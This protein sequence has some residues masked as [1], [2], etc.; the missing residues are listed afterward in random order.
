MQAL[1]K[2]T[3]FVPH[4]LTEVLAEL[5]A[6]L[7]RPTAEGVL[8]FPGIGLAVSLLKRYKPELVPWI[9]REFVPL[10]ADQEPRGPQT[11]QDTWWQGLPMDNGI[12]DE[13]LP[14]WFTEIWIPISRTQ[15]V[16]TTLRDYFNRNGL[17]ATGTFSIE[18]YGAKSN[19]FWMSPSSDGEPVVRVDF[20]WFGYNAGDPAKEFYQ[21]FWDLLAQF[22]F[23]L[24]WGKYLPGDP[25][26]EKRWAKYFAAR[27][28]HW[29][30]FMALRA[31]LDPKNIFLT[32]YWR[33]HLGLEEA[34]PRRWVPSRLPKWSPFPTYEW[35][36]AERWV[37][38][39]SWLILLA[40]AVGLLAAHAPFVA[41]TPWTTCQ[42]EWSPLG[43]ALTFHYLEV[44]IVC[45]QIF[46]AIYGLRGLRAHAEKYM[47]LLGF[48]VPLL[49]LF[50]LFEVLLI[51]DSFRRGAPTWEIAAL[52]VVASMLMSGVA[53]GLLV[54]LKLKTALTPP[55]MRFMP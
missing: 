50:T 28:K 51:L 46:F 33:E 45:Y 23:K 1:L 47:T 42:K 37:K 52:F 12:K 36:V 25:L 32:S 39:Y 15:E 30:D 54:H 4:A 10:D 11:F 19:P 43:C 18:L 44:P 38:A 2:K 17:S 49:G 53:L 8:D 55:S 7:M 41:G 27:F 13:L 21:Q 6:A 48:T 14:T 16:M 40:V 9:L 29:G 24:H 31:K 35:A 3:G 22:N 34:R 20:F 26:P 5:I